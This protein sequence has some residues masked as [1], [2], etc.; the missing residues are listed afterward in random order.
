MSGRVRAEAKATQCVVE[1]LKIFQ[2]RKTNLC[3]K[4][5]TS[6][7]EALGYSVRDGNKGGHKVFTHSGLGEFASSSFNC[8]HGRNPEIK[9][10]YI[11][12]IIKL[13]QQYKEE[14]VTYLANKGE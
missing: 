12:K 3:C 8:G 10:A 14:L 9:P 2:Q 5:V 7:L 13:V 1:T 6:L 11:G 4:D